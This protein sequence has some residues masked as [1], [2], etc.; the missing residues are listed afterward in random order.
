MKTQKANENALISTL[1]N[2][3]A[4]LVDIFYPRNCILTGDP[5][6]QGDFRYLADWVIRRLP[7]IKDPRCPTCGHPFFGE[8]EDNP[9]CLHCET[10]NPAFENGRCGYLLSRD[11]RIL[12]HS[13]KYRKK[14]YLA[15]DIARL[16]SLAPG[17]LDFLEDAIIIPVPLHPKKLRHRGFNQTTEILR[18]LDPLVPGG[19]RICP[20]IQRLVDTDSQTRSNRRERMKRIKGAFGLAEDAEPPPHEARCVIFDDVFTTGATLNT[21][22]QVLRKA[23]WERIDVAAFVHG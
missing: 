8:V 19:L 12:L 14:A 18:H 3:S 23:G 16:L 20:L 5:L 7:V 2:W 9:V 21:C 1:R 15:P 4:P 13:L 10:L 17:F 6:G 11:T 22:S